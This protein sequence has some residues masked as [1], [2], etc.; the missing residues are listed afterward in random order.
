MSVSE[1]STIGRYALLDPLVH[2]EPVRAVVVPP[3]K[4][5]D[6]LW[7]WVLPQG[8]GTDA[9]VLRNLADE[10]SV[11]LPARHPNLLTW[12]DVGRDA[13]RAYVVTE[14]L[15]GRSFGSVLAATQ[16]AGVQVPQAFVGWVLLGACRAR[17]H[18]HA[19]RDARGR[20]LSRQAKPMDPSDLYVSLEGEVKL[21]GLRTWS[22]L[23]N[24]AA[25]TPTAPALVSSPERLRGDVEDERSDVHVLAQLAYMALSGRSPFEGDQVTSRLASQKA[26]APSLRALQ[27]DVSAE[28]DDLL[29]RSL[30]YDPAR[31][32][33]SCRTLGESLRALLLA[34]TSERRVQAQ[35]GAWL[36][37][38]F[39][40]EI[41]KE[42]AEISAALA[43]VREASDAAWL[44][45]HARE[46]KAR[47]QGTLPGLLAAGLVALLGV[48]ATAGAG[49]SEPE[50]PPVE[51]VD[52]AHLV[53]RPTPA[54]RVMLDGRGQGS[55]SEVEVPDLP[56]GSVPLRVEADGFEPWL[57]TATLVAG[58][59][60]T[61]EASLNPMVVE[62]P[63]VLS[64]TSRPTG[65]QV[66]VD[67]VGVGTTPTTYRLTTGR[68]QA[69]VTFQRAGFSEQAVALSGLKPGTR[70]SVSVVLVPGTGRV[71]TATAAPTTGTLRVLVS[72]ASW[73]SVEVDGAP[74]GRNAPLAGAR[75]SAGPHTIRVRNEGDRIDHTET[76]EIPP[77]GE[78][79]LRVSPK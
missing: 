1:S 16:R 39:T 37:D 13:A 44:G 12:W 21:A 30:A 25:H 76:I 70:R 52:A 65:A 29:K 55:G 77:G 42:R 18:L 6:V 48:A 53:V 8:A 34:D 64:I 14:A 9:E 66:R 27:S 72:G 57:G 11:A 60:T 56:A 71:A 41:A 24:A 45:R 2:T 15:T 58:G 22:A 46:R 40:T 59:T 75:L 79:T 31:R 54:A 43:A 38:L 36:H 50:V 4:A 3:S 73:A 49:L 17:H 5:A 51:R 26:G 78:V 35:L 62:E 23:S 68:P 33:E 69:R 67:G 32:P 47:R 19:R 20:P 7:M 28:L 74:L 10:A 63:V 61:V